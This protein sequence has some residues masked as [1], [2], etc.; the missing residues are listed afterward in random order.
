MVRTDGEGDKWWP[1]GYNCLHLVLKLII[2]H[3]FLTV[4][5]VYICIFTCI[6]IQVYIYIHSGMFSLILLLMIQLSRVTLVTPS[7]PNDDPK[8]IF[9]RN[10]EHW[11]ANRN[12]QLS[13]MSHNGHGYDQHERALDAVYW[14]RDSSFIL[15]WMAWGSTSYER[16]PE[17][18]FVVSVIF[19]YWAGMFF[20]IGSGSMV[21]LSIQPWKKHNSKSSSVS[22]PNGKLGLF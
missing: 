16:I 22:S 15:F 21:R 14:L 19:C 12:L 4:T 5:Y 1:V 18:L 20:G 2:T 9:I 10:R 3:I 7:C 6:S 8:L 13:F 11:L 17:S